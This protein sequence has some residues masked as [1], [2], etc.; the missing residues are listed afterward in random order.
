MRLLWHDKSQYWLCN[1]FITVVDCSS[2]VRKHAKNKYLSFY[3]YS[4]HNYIKS[5]Y[6]SS[7]LYLNDGFNT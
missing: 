4:L 3:K 5:R 6:E 2:H 1:L 7:G